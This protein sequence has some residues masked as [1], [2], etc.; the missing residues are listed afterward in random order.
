[1]LIA[2]ESKMKTTTVF[3]VDERLTP[4]LIKR[5]AKVFAGELMKCVVCGREQESDP[6]AQTDWRAI[7]VNGVLHYVCASEFPP[8]WAS[9]KRFEAAYRR[10]FAAIAAMAKRN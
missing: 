5:S 7:E 8:N 4:E 10:V 1:M 6:N 9:A 3:A 2:F